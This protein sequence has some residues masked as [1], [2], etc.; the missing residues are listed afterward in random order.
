MIDILL[1]ILAEGAKITLPEVVPEEFVEKEKPKPLPK[2]KKKSSK[3]TTLPIQKEEEE[4]TSKL[5]CEVP[6]SAFNRPS[7]YSAQKKYS[8]LQKA[9]IWREIL[10]PPVSKQRKRR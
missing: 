7:I 3:K 5:T 10:G 8:D 9:M 6:H 2:Q 1:E 4:D